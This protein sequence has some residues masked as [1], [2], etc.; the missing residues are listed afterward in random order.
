M[1]ALHGGAALGSLVSLAG[2]SGTSAGIAPRFD[3]GC[4]IGEPSTEVGTGGCSAV[5]KERNLTLA[6]LSKLLA[7]E[8][9]KLQAM[10]PWMPRMSP[11]RPKRMAAVAAPTLFAPL[12][13]AAFTATA[14]VTPTSMAPMI[15]ST[16]PG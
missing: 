3:A 9:D 1:G 4:C 15:R 11:V 14:G 7:E 6:G 12:S 8:T 16:F 2:A 5:G 13:P 10:P